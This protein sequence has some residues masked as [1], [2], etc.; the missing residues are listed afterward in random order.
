[1]KIPSELYNT[2]QLISLLTKG[3]LASPL[4]NS[5]SCMNVWS[6]ANCIIGRFDG[7]TGL[8]YSYKDAIDTGTYDALMDKLIKAEVI[9]K[10]DLLMLE[11][12]R[13]SN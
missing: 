12:E 5:L 9:T 11:L 7:G 10:G 8:C 6:C 3:C 4:F 13:N 2:D 1:M